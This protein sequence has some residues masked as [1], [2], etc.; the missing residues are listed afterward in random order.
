M[1]RPQREAYARAVVQC[2]PMELVGGLE[3]RS[4]DKFV[5]LR[6]ELH[7]LL[8][9]VALGL[10]ATGS[11]LDEESLAHAAELAVRMRWPDRAYFLEVGHD[12]QGWIQIFQPY[13]L[14]R[15]CTCANT[16]T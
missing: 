11:P 8:C 2:G 9:F 3:Y 7:T 10:V 1:I 13:G 15:S 14:P 12:E 5:W 6:N 4:G 16:G